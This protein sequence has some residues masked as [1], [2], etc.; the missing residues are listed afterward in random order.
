MTNLLAQ[1]NQARTACVH[2]LPR[3]TLKRVHFSERMS[4]ETN[5]Y[6]ADVWLDG[7]KVA[8]AENDGGGGETVIR[9][10]DAERIAAFRL[11]LAAAQGAQPA[12]FLMFAFTDAV[13]D[14]L[15]TWVSERQLKTTIS[16][17]HR[18]GKH[19]IICGD[20]I[21]S[22]PADKMP[23]IPQ[24]GDKVNGRV[25]TAVHPFGGAK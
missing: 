7:V 1:Y 18:R 4:R 10:L 6:A 12:S 23:V 25:V 14:A 24:I 3:L 22:A 20:V 13:D 11:E 15:A 17:L 8:T 19:V 21:M 9:W 5:C 16:R 2:L